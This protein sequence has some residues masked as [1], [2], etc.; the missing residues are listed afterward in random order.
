MAADSL[1]NYLAAS[2]LNSMLRASPARYV[3]G[4]GGGEV[5]SVLERQL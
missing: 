5:L 3:G 2:S 4:N 1:V